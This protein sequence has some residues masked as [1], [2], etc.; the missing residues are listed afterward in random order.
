MAGKLDEQD[1]ESLLRVFG[2]QEAY[3]KSL[4]QRHWQQGSNGKWWSHDRFYCAVGGCP[5]HPVS[6]NGH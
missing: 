2:S 6:S 4:P 3:E 1:T 5:E